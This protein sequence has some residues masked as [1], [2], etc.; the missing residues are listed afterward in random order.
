[1]TSKD[2]K[3]EQVHVTEAQAKEALDKATRR[4][5]R[6]D[7]ETIVQRQQ[8]LDEKLKQV[9]GK[10]LKMINQVKL[11]FEMIR[12][13]CQGAYKEVPWASIAM[14]VGALA[15]FLSPVD[16]IPDFIPVIGYL[17]DAMVVAL[18]IKAIQEDLRA[19]CNF[20]KYETVQY[21]D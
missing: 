2:A 20:K 15:Y 5:K 3:H 13:Y 1:M 11:L 17:D 7:V 10:L 18:A 9:P 14:A 21:F 4:V 16:L 6:A 8:E 19:Y 12:D